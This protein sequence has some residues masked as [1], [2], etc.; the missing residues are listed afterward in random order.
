MD[1]Y[2]VLQAAGGATLAARI[3]LAEPTAMQREVE[4]IARSV[5]I[6]QPRRQAPA[7]K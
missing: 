3:P 5:T 4:R 7:G 2:L 1:Y 6:S